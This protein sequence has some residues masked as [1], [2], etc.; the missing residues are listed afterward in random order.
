MQGV[1]YR[2]VSSRQTEIKRGDTESM[3]PQIKYFISA[4]ISSF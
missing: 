2:E 1:I 3:S 4:P